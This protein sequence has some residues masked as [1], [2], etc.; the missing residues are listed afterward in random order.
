M[1]GI[2]PEATGHSARCALIPGHGRTHA[3]RE[4]RTWDVFHKFCEELIGSC[5][6]RA[7]GFWRTQLFWRQAGVYRIFSGREA[8]VRHSPTQYLLTGH[9]SPLFVFA[10]SI[11]R[12]T[13]RVSC[14][15]PKKRKQEQREK[16]TNLPVSL[17]SPVLTFR[18]CLFHADSRKWF[19]TS[20][21]LELKFH[22]TQ[23]SVAQLFSYES[24]PQRVRYCAC[25]CCLGT[26]RCEKIP[27]WIC[28]I[29]SSFGHKYIFTTTLYSARQW[30]FVSCW[31]GNTKFRR[32]FNAAN[33]TI[34]KKN[35][36]TATT[37]LLRKFEIS[38]D[39]FTFQEIWDQLW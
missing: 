27:C 4:M 31:H 10:V 28:N 14:S 8:P 29:W 26:I 18:C 20:I 36:S 16:L 11:P 25:Y 7:E 12:L 35:K 38:F 17:F 21:D 33:T 23:R 34:C 5:T 37:L 9:A 22:V 2:A 24:W 15:Q 6:L 13:L 39:H 19:G 1:G 32:N 30:I 3:L